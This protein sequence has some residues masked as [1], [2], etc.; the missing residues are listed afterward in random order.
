MAGLAVALIGSIFAR[1]VFFHT[2]Q[3]VAP[4]NAGD[5]LLSYR[6][7]FVRRGLIGELLY[8]LPFLTDLH[9]V[10]IAIKSLSLA[11]YCS[12]FAMLAA[13]VQRHTRSAAATLLVMVQPFLF[14]FPVLTG[15]WIREDLM[16]LVCFYAVLGP[17]RDSAVMANVV[18]ILAIVTHEAYGVVLLPLVVVLR[19]SADSRERAWASALLRASARFSPSIAVLLIM[20]MYPGNREVASR[21]AEAWAAKG[22]ALPP[23]AAPALF[24]L[25]QKN[26]WR[27]G[28][29]M[30]RS[31]Y[32][33]KPFYFVFWGGAI[34]SA[35]L[36]LSLAAGL[37]RSR[38]IAH[39]SSP[40]YDARVAIEAAAG[41][42]I[43]LVGFAPL[44]LMATDFGRWVFLWLAASAAVV[45]SPRR[46]ELLA[47]IARV[48][49]GSVTTAIRGACR[50][51]TDRWTARAPSRAWCVG[52]L[53]GSL[54]CL[55]LPTYAMEGCCTWRV[56]TSFSLAARLLS[57][58][59]GLH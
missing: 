26:V 11:A 59:F 1:A 46:L 10:E 29:D 51:A 5:F 27:M 52:L 15:Q 58:A 44:F 19:A 53:A 34:V 9:R 49:P 4:I 45:F 12:A 13:I 6:G 47:F 23:G 37:V 17:L 42:A 43:T 2:L 30:T 18:S 54:F 55:P 48:L 39:E 28:F 3:D 50:Q 20:V 36:L 8:R 38:D 22:I 40:P 33:D 25:A 57:L 21:I 31:N 56:V 41:V 32:L 24:G 16:L 7:G 14:G 35:G